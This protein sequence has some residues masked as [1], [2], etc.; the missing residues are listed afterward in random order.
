VL[1]ASAACSLMG[2]RPSHLSGYGKVEIRLPWK[3]KT[4]RSIRASLTIHIIRVWDSGSL[5]DSD[6]G[7]GGSIPPTL[8]NAPLPKWPTGLPAKQ[9]SGSSILPR[10]SIFLGSFS[11]KTAA[12]EAAFRGSSP[13]PRAK[14]NVQCT[15]NS[16]SVFWPGA[17]G[18]S[19]K[20]VAPVQ[21]HDQQNY[22]RS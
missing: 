1:V 12:F 3:Q 11:G 21:S 8:T 9:L 5:P 13:L 17:C 10:R 19:P 18:D 2:E 16:G 15:S 7:S 22:V 4:A 6:S 14:H 20:R